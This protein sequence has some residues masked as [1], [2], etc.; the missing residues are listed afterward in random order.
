M[1]T[2]A[3]FVPTFTLTADGASEASHKLPPGVSFLLS[4]FADQQWHEVTLGQAETISV[5]ATGTCLVLVVALDGGRFGFTPDQGGAVE[6]TNLAAF[7]AMVDNVSRQGI[8][9]NLDMAIKGNGAADAR[10][11]WC[12]VADPS[13]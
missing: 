10:I 6:F 8:G 13:A 4:G 5:P 3:S 12:V 11:A 1:A 2:E 7:V 9:S